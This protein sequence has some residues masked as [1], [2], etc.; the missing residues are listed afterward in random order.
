MLIEL[1]SNNVT[2]KFYTQHVENFYIATGIIESSHESSHD[3]NYNTAREI[4]NIMGDTVSVGSR[5]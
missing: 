3:V 2:C 5:K 4:K 1:I